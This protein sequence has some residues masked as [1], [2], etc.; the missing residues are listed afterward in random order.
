M[1]HSGLTALQTLGI[2]AEYHSEIREILKQVNDGKITP[3]AGLKK[4][5]KIQAKEA[6]KNRNK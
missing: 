2:F 5:R 3:I 6:E 4:A 1:K